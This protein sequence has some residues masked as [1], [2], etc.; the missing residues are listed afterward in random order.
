M[1]QDARKLAIEVSA[2][3]M[4]VRVRCDRSDWPVEKVLETVS[5]EAENLGLALP[6]DDRVW[7]ERIRAA[8]EAPGDAWEVVILRGDPPAPSV[9]ERIEWARDF[10]STD[11]KVDQASGRIDYRERA[12][13]QN[14]AAGERVARIVPGEPGG[15]GRESH[16]SAHW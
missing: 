1:Q 3:R 7:H 6:E 4:E 8:I 2:D 14:V 16:R 11:F 15:T 9:D 5:V 13:S 12:V 10:F